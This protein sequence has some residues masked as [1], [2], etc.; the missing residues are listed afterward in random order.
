MAWAAETYLLSDALDRE[1]RLIK[2]QITRGRQTLSQHVGVRGHAQALAKRALE[3]TH[4]D[5]RQQGELV[6]GD[7]LREVFFYVVHD[8]LDAVRRQTARG[9]RGRPR[10]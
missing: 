7:R 5:T 10:Q 3:V 2:E 6:Q 9:S 1:S 4:A 8:D